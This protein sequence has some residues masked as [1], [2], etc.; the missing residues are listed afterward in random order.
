MEHCL[1][2]KEKKTS[3]YFWTFLYMGILKYAYLCLSVRVCL[4]VCLKFFNALDNIIPSCH[5]RAKDLI[6][7]AYF[8]AVS[9]QGEVRYYK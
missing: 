5:G 9:D 1:L 8:V 2:F 7:P 3:L 4:L 6:N